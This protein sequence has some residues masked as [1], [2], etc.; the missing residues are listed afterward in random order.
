MGFTG[1]PILPAFKVT[2]L[3][4]HSIKD[5]SLMLAVHAQLHY[6]AIPMSA[7]LSRS[8]FEGH[9]CFHNPTMAA[10]AAFT[11]CDS[12]SNGA[13]R[14]AAPLLPASPGR[15]RRVPAAGAIAA[16]IAAARA[17]IVCERPA[18]CTRGQL[19]CALRTLGIRS[20]E[21]VRT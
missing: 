2:L 17:V 8:Y 18:D 5:P 12:N 4:L 6:G 9:P 10:A 1:P 19:A 13:S 15:P 11:A 7:V 16:V 14:S 21:A 3:S 20:V